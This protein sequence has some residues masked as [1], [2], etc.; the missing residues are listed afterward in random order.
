MTAAPEQSSLTPP[1]REREDKLRKNYK[2]LLRAHGCHLS[3]K[4]FKMLADRM[5]RAMFP[6][7][8][9][10]KLA[11]NPLNAMVYV[12]GVRETVG[13]PLEDELIMGAM[14]N[15]RKRPND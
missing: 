7:W 6:E 11:C 14:M 5:R 1:K 2:R 10:D 3:V 13:A 8:T 4:E 9:P 15:K 12:A